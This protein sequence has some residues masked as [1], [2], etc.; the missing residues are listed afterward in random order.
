MRTVESCDQIASIMLKS[1]LIVLMS[2]LVAFA[3][4]FR[5]GHFGR[6]QKETGNRHHVVARWCG[7]RIESHSAPS[8]LLLT[9][10]DLGSP[11]CLICGSRP[12]P[13]GGRSHQAV[14][15]IAVPKPGP[16]PVAAPG[17]QS[18]RRQHAPRT[19]VGNRY[20]RKPRRF[21]S[22]GGGPYGGPKERRLLR[23]L[24]SGAAAR[25]AALGS[26]PQR[27]GRGSYHG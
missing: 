17:P 15:G 2:V 14:R 27:L 18:G 24:E 11:S 21:G 7:I 10:N 5:R 25:R 4:F 3:I 13:V 9:K 23:D 6:G 26:R 12:L 20:G 8:P 16:E 1:S 22:A 19:R